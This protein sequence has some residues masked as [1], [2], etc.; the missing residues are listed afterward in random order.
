MNVLLAELSINLK[1]MKSSILFFNLV[2]F[3]LSISCQA[4]SEYGQF[5]ETECPI[6]ISEELASCL[7]GYK[8]NQEYILPAHK[9]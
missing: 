7:E 2:I 3:S 4:Q 1:P 9:I 8:K 6:K 5:T